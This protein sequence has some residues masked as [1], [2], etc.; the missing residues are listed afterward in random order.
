[1]VLLSSEWC[2]LILPQ[3][4]FIFQFIL[5]E[6]CKYKHVLKDANCLNFEVLC[7]FGKTYR[8]SSHIKFQLFQHFNTWSSYRIWRVALKEQKTTRFLVVLQLCMSHANYTVNRVETDLKEQV[9]HHP[10]EETTLCILPNSKQ[11]LNIYFWWVTSC[12]HLSHQPLPFSL[13]RFSGAH[14]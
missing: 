11:Q 14:L 9:S 5:D 6:C 1:M 12:L 8:A 4:I 13:P 10:K 3:S 2:V 7:R